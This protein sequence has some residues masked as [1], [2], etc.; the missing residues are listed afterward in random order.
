M[1][2]MM[3]FVQLEDRLPG[4]EVMADERPACSNCVSTR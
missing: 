1:V 4:V 3:P 2:V